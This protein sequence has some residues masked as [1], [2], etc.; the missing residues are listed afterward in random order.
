MFSSLLGELTR[1]RQFQRVLLRGLDRED[2]GRFIELASGVTPPAGMLEAVHRQTEGNPLFVTEVVRLLVQEG[3]LTQ[4]PSTGSGRTEERDSWSVRIP[5]G[6]REVIGRRLDRLSQR[7]NETLTVASL[8]GREF[9]SEQ[10]SPLIEDISADRLLEVLEEALAARVLEELPRSVGRYQ[11]THALIQ[12]TL[13]GELS[14]TRR[15]RLHGRIAETLEDLYRDDAESHAAE[16]AHHFAQAEA[17][18]GTEKLVHYS[19]LAGERALTSYAWEEAQFQ[20]ERGLAARGLPVV[21][22]DRLPDKQAADLLYGFGRARVGTARRYNTQEAVNALARAFDY[23]FDNG[24]GFAAVAVARYP[25]PMGGVRTGMARMIRSALT[26]IPDNSLEVGR[27]LSRLGFEAGRVEG[28]YEQAAA[29]FEQAL[30]IARGEEDATLEMETLALSADVDF[31]HNRTAQSVNTSLEAIEMALR[32]GNPQVEANARFTALRALVT[33][34]EV[35]GA[36]AQALALSDVAERLGDRYW[37]GTALQTLCFLSAYLGEEEES[38][39]FG[40]RALAVSPQDEQVLILLATIEYDAGNFSQGH[41]YLERALEAMDLI[42]PGPR[43]VFC[44][45]SNLI[46]RVARLT[47]DV[48][49]FDVAAGAAQVVLSLPSAPPFYRLSA[50]CGLALQAVVSGD[51]GSAREQYS[52]IVS[53]RGKFIVFVGSADRV[54]GLLAYTLGDLDIALGHFEDAIA[55]CRKGYRPELAW[56]CCDYADMLKERDGP[57]DKEKAV[58]L[59]DESL[60]I[61]SELGMRPL[62]ERVL[63]RRDI[64]GA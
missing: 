54:L 8:V 48:Q 35:Q 60:A 26:V 47:G 22:E 49:H 18:V 34:G 23:Y 5:E 50:R 24:E 41:Q 19:L 27:L 25:V 11:F 33:I 57:G 3:E 64:L 39:K 21:G 29:A 42:P 38:R 51:V 62:M 31:F 17:V 37:L 30:S 4:D 28:D 2:V 43:A 56:T 6:V 16:L 9:T 1:E 58:A 36:Q 45:A 63:S 14:I 55:F 40:E 20:F 10:I 13:A 32:R 7:C 52:E 15:V 61:S 59:L 44:F 53:E 12:E 46:P